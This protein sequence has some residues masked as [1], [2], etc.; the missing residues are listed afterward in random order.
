MEGT[1]R[2]VI[3]K[4]L[5]GKVE[6]YWDNYEEL[7]RVKSWANAESMRGYSGNPFIYKGRLIKRVRTNNDLGL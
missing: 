2:L 1:R 3:V 6:E 4:D 5:E 7:A